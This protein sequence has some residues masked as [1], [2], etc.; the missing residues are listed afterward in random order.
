MLLIS[1]FIMGFTLGAITTWHFTLY[2]VHRVIEEHI[3]K[4]VFRKRGLKY[5]IEKIGQYRK[6]M[7]E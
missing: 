5:K 3:E 6:E 2:V 4:G 1:A 7:S